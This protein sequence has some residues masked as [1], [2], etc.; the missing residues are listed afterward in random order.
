MRPATLARLT[1]QLARNS[2]LI[3]GEGVMGLFDGAPAPAGGADGGGDGTPD[4]STDGSTADLAAR[5]GWPVILIIDAKGQG[6]SAAALLKGFAGFRQGVTY[7][8]IAVQLTG[9]CQPGGHLTDP[10]HEAGLNRIAV[11]QWMLALNDD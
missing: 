7:L 11:K 3:V 5:T 10:A 2:A 8:D 6:A 9:I 1:A 4:G